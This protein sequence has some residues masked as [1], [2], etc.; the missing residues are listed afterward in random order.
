MTHSDN[1]EKF[2]RFNFANMHTWDLY[3]LFEKLDKWSMGFVS[4]KSLDEQKRKNI[5]D[6]PAIELHKEYNSS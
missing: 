6:T 5:I 2:F 1:L 4:S 3:E